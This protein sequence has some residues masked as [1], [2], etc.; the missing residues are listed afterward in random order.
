[1]AFVDHVRAGIG[2]P[3]VWDELKNQ[4]YLGDT[5][6]AQELPQCS[7]RQAFAFEIARSQ[8]R[9]AAPP[10]THFTKLLERKSA[11]VQVYATGCY[12]VKDV[13]RAYGVHY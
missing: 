12:S 2:L 1:M 9:S 5:D 6:F 10:V 7:R 11:M 8:C 4:L 13:G 3:S